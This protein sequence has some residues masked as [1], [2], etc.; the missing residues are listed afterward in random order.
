MRSM[1]AIVRGRFPSWFCMNNRWL[2]W[3][4][5]RGQ[6]SAEETAV[7]LC[8]VQDTCR[9]SKGENAGDKDGCPIVNPSR[10]KIDTHAKTLQA[11]LSNL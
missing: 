7:L 3:H 10:A 1:S 2:V 6:A 4:T 8:D 11:K 5:R 9:Q